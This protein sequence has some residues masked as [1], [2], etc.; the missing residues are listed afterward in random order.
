MTTRAN[1]RG[2]TQSVG[3]RGGRMA[4]GTSGAALGRSGD[5]VDAPG[6][7]HRKAPGAD[8]TNIEARSQAAKMRTSLPMSKTSRLRGRG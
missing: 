6:K 4:G 2:R 5:K 7:T 8:T 3:N 1:T